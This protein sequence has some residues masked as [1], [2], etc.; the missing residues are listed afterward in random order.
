MK[1]K[2]NH[3]RFLLLIVLLSQVALAQQPQP[4]PS[5]LTIERIFDGDE[6]QP[7]RFGGFRWLKD[8]NSFARLEPSP[9]IKGSMDLVRY[10]A[11]TNKR[12]VLL[13]AE[14]LVPKGETKP[15]AIQGYEWS[16]DDK[17]LLIYTNSKKVW[18]LNT[19]GDYWVLDTSTGKLTKLGDDAKP[20]TLM[21][22]KFSPDASRVGYVRE[23][24][25]Y[26]ENIDTGKITRLTSNGSPTMTAGTNYTLG[27]SNGGTADERREN[28]SAGTHAATFTGNNA[29]GHQVTLGMAFK[30]PAAGGGAL[31]IFRENYR[32]MKAA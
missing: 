1:T 10:E 4:A 2:I 21:F 15:L 13:P 32:R 30:V 7:A 23:N 16:A 14:K 3:F 27:A 31:P 19:K 20:S 5:G 28:V 24:D 12:D 18:R 6:F 11:A 22:A 8:G 17:R 26:V 29:F 25:L 9:T